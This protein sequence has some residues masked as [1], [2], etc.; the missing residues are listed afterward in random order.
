MDV[1]RNTSPRFHCDWCKC[2]IPGHPPH[3][4]G[5]LSEAES[6]RS[7]QFLNNPCQVDVIDESPIS[8]PAS[9][10]RH[11]FFVEP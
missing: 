6:E 3:R 9:D 8:S 5:I 1:V 7:A 11:L 2:H 4:N 10:P